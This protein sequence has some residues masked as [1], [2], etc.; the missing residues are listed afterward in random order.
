MPDRKH[1]TQVQFICD[2]CGKEATK[3]PINFKLIHRNHSLTYLIKG[4]IVNKKAHIPIQKLIPAVSSTNIKHKNRIIPNNIDTVHTSFSISIFVIVIIHC[5][6][7]YNS[8]KE[9]CN[10]C[11]KPANKCPKFYSKTYCNYY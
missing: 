3:A 8:C 6:T 2:C 11:K 9:K 10:S 5:R 1:R 7:I 4:I